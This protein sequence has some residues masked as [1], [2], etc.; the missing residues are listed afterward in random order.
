MRLRNVIWWK[1]VKSESVKAK[2]D[3]S[4]LQDD[5]Y[6]NGCILKCC[7]GSLVDTDRRFRNAYCLHHKGNDRPDRGR[8]LL[9]NVGQNLPDHRPRRPHLQTKSCLPHTWQ[10]S[11]VYT[12]SLRSERPAQYIS[13]PLHDVRNLDNR[14][15]NLLRLR[16]KS[17]VGES[18]PQPLSNFHALLRPL[19][20]LLR[21]V[22]QNTGSRGM[23]SDAWYKL[24]GN[25]E[26]AYMKAAGKIVTRYCARIIGYQYQCK[27]VYIKYF[28]SLFIW[29]YLYPSLSFLVVSLSSFL[30]TFSFLS[31][32][33]LSSLYA[34]P[35]LLVKYLPPHFYFITSFPSVSLCTHL[36]FTSVPMYTN[37][38][39][40]LVFPISFPFLPVFLFPHFSIYVPFRPIFPLD[41][42]WTNYGPSKVSVLPTTVCQR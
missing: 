24:T 26:P 20:V 38:F 8:K 41:Q 25:C 2:T 7:A 6:E 10:H 37:L 1:A 36:L 31:L 19:C 16:E 29:F 3:I 40:Y 30:F 42:R 28:I 17:Q 32:F 21:P 18:N 14:A 4:G 23:S 11:F 33:F 39:S 27:K 5:E 13:L 35:F 15:S 9:W 22:V 12:V 34:V